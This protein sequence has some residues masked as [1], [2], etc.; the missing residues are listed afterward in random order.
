M[1]G[2]SPME[3]WEMT[4]IEIY[5]GIAGFKE[6]HTSESTV[7]MTKGELENMMELNPD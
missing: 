1:M 2:V 4:P 5:M 7:P 6:F 3:F